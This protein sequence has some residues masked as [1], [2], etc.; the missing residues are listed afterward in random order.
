MCYTLGFWWPLV[1]HDTT[2][3]LLV[4]RDPDSIFRSFCRIGWREDTQSD[5]RAVLRRISSH[6]QAA[7]RSI[8]DLAIPHIVI[9]Y[10]EYADKADEVANRLSSVLGP[11]HEE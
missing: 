4:R 6:M 8:T 7:E 10:Q 5:R 2:R 9:D 11:S 3:V 1:N